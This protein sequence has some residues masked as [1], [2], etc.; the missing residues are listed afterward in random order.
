M[1]KFVRGCVMAGLVLALV[2]CTSGAKTTAAASATSHPAS[3]VSATPHCDGSQRT[4]RYPQFASAFNRHD[5]ALAVDQ[6]G[7]HHEF[8]WKDPSDPEVLTLGEIHDHLA[9]LYDLGVRLPA[10]VTFEAAEYEPPDTEGHDRPAGSSVAF[11]SNGPH[12]WGKVG[13]DCASGKIG[14]MVI[15]EWTRA[16]AGHAPLGPSPSA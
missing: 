12:F 8:T 15:D 7:G 10:T 4:D 11:Y 1:S 2:G 13:I 14:Y 16:I 5:L 9:S 3:V 6:F